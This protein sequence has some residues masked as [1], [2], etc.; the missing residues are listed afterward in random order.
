[1]YK[2]LS[3]QDFGAYQVVFL[4]TSKYEAWSTSAK[5]LYQINPHHISD[6]GV[7]ER[8]WARRATP[9]HGGGYLVDS[10]AG[11]TNMKQSHLGILSSLLALEE[12][13][14]VLSTL[15]TWF[16]GP[17]QRRI[18]SNIRSHTSSL[19]RRPSKS[20]S[21]DTVVRRALGGLTGAATVHENITDT[22]FM[23]V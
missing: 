9:Q 22:V 3:K 4:F 5:N 16:H 12:H 2:F 19:T 10:T 11:A 18:R 20:I 14:F 6:L 23:R 17:W 7:R 1:M 21:K 8:E 15:W 13:T